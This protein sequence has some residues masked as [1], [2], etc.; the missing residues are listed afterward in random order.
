MSISNEEIKTIA[1]S[2]KLSLSD[3]DVSR[4]EERLAVID[5]RMK[6]IS[7]VN[8]E[9]VDS[10]FFGNEVRNVFREDEIV[11]SETREELFRNVPQQTA[12]DF[13][14]VPAMIEDG[15]EGA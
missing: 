3:E 12:D 10:T 9:G 13:I 14:E 11:K 15:K 6:R 4:L 5:E 8:T 2:A 1:A 7:E